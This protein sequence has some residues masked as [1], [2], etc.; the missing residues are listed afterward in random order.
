MPILRLENVKVRYSS[1]PVVHGVSIDA[2]RGETIAVVG[3]NGAGKSTL[4]KAIMGAQRAFE[5]KILFERTEIQGLRTEQI[6]RLG[7]V[8]VPEDR[9]L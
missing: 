2:F 4:L 9:K 3:S 1:A 8:Y 7:I 6:V 5:G